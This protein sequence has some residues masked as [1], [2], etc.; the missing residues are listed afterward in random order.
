[1]RTP[2]TGARAW[3]AGVAVAGATALSFGLGLYHL[4]SR[5]LSLDEGYTWVISSQS[6]S[7]IFSQQRGD[8]GHLFL[9]YVMIHFLVAWFGNGAVVMRLPSVLAGV[10][11]VPLVY[12]LAR[13]LASDRVAGLFAAWL[14]AVSTPL[15]FWQQNAREYAFIV[16]FA[17]ASALVLVTAVQSA[18]RWGLVAWAALIVMA[19]Y[20]N[21]GAAF[22]PAAQLLPFLVWPRA[23][24]LMKPLAVSVGAAAVVVAIPIAAAT[25]T[26]GSILLSPPNGAAVKELATF[27]SSGAG[28]TTA[29]TATGYALMAITAVLWAATIVTVVVGLYRNGRT[30]R[31]FGLVFAL[32]GL[33]VPPLLVWVISEAVHPIFADRY[34]IASLPAAA[35]VVGMVLAR[36][37]P[38][39][40]GLCGLALLMAFH[41]DALAPSYNKPIDDFSGA[42]LSVA[43][44]AR[45]DDCI[46]FFE[47]DGRLLYDYYAA[48][49]Q[50]SGDGSLAL[51]RQ[52]LPSELYTDDPLEVDLYATFSHEFVASQQT[53]AAVAAAARDCPRLWLFESDIGSPP[54]LATGV[55]R[56]AGLALL[57]SNI[58]TAYRLQSTKSYPGI[59]LLLFDRPAPPTSP[60]VAP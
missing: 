15:V 25:L 31:T 55:R 24:A 59:K 10:A 22:L 52:V 60:A 50:P 28:S 33:V 18:S 56:R 35:V 54:G 40:V 48:R 4:G 17:V 49:D 30:K 41:C 19:C 2:A 38:R 34:L 45:P 57:V 8:G 39:A 47:D 26:D 3:L 23:R 21:P 6:I 43:V 58:E 16:F 42:T 37:R 7:T 32:C 53:V 46:T 5:S 11:A 9:Y 27:L 44:S 1:M 14:F 51:P 13:R 29:V 36:L 12:L 20:T